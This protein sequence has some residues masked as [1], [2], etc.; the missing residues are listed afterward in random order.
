MYDDDARTSCTI[1]EL[2]PVQDCRTLGL[3]LLIAT[4]PGWTRSNQLQRANVADVSPLH[5]ACNRTA[6]TRRLEAEPTGLCPGALLTYAVGP[7]SLSFTV[8]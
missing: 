6:P 5:L 2:D 4:G 8:R 3:L 7:S 1:R